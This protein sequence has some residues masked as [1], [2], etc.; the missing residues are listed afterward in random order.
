MASQLVGNFIAQFSDANGLL[1][2]GSVTFYVAGSSTTKQAIYTTSAKT[3]ELAN[4]QT[5]DAAGAL[6]NEIWLEGNYNIVVR[7]AD[8]TTFKTRDN[9]DASTSSAA[10]LS[11]MESAQDAKAALGSYTEVNAESI[12]PVAGDIIL[13][14]NDRNRYELRSGGDYTADPE[15]DSYNVNTGVGTNWN[16]LSISNA[17]ITQSNLDTIDAAVA[18]NTANIA[19][20]YGMEFSNDASDSANDLSFTAGVRRDS[21][22]TQNIATVALIKA[23]DAA[24]GLGTAQGGMPAG[25]LPKSAD[26]YRIFAIRNTVTGVTDIGFDT[27]ST[28]INLL[29]A[30]V[31]LSA[32]FT[33]YR[34]IGWIRADSASTYN[35]VQF[36]AH[37]GRLIYNQKIEARAFAAATDGAETITLAC[38]P[39]ATVDGLFTGYAFPNTN[40]GSALY[41]LFYD[42]DNVPSTIDETTCDLAA[43]RSLDHTNAGGSGNF[44]RRVNASGQIGVYCDTSNTQNANKYDLAM[45]T[46]GFIYDRGIS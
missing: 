14:D 10:V 3:T 35:L 27:S 45:S 4:P 9:Y 33:Q 34:Q 11:W 8:G 22:E 13:G 18:A 26:Y 32:G 46:I 16:D 28:A 7:R 30:A 1:V 25:L 24:F 37:K 43:F 12:V 19:T 41:A 39:D 2:G 15:S 31:L 17:P 44:Q 20:P 6:P 40:A 38:P 5:L 42:L 21:T 36:K 29:A 23:T